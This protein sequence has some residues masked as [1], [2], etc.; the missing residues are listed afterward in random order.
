MD[1][2]IGD[3]AIMKKPHP[4]GSMKWQITRIGADMKIKCETCGRVVMLP[5]L[6]FLKR[7]KKVEVK[8]NG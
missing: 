5:R 3:V 4:C 1:L 7:I 2:K 6:D 8:N